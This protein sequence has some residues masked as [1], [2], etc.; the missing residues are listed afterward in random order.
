MKYEFFTRQWPIF[1]VVASIQ[2]RPLYERAKL[3]FFEWEILRPLLKWLRLQIF[4]MAVC[5]QSNARRN[6][7]DGWT[8]Q[9][10][11]LALGMCWRFFVFVQL[12][13]CLGTKSLSE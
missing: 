10:V 7:V 1:I 12:N 9:R 8:G 4:F 2:T 5:Y 11:S 6:V 3:Y 13:V